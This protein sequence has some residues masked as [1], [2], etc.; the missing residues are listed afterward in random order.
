MH[1]QLDDLNEQQRLAVTQTPSAMLVFAGAGSGKTRVITYRIAWLIE[2]G[3]R[4]DSILAVTFTNKAAREMRERIEN[5]IGEKARNLWMGTFHSVCGRLLRI[6][7]DKIGIDKNF[8]IYDDADQLS[9][10]RE[11]LKK[12]GKDEKSFTP[13]SVLSEIS[14]AK[15]KLIS[16]E[17]Y[18]R[19]SMSYF[20]NEVAKLYPKYQE[21]LR[22]N[23]ALD[24]DDMIMFTV[25]LLQERKDV[26]DTIQRR[27]SHVLVDEFQ[28]VNLAQYELVRLLAEKHGN[29]T[30]VGD[31][32]QSI[33]AW[34]GADV[35]L[36][37]KFS[38][39]FKDAKIIMLE[40]NYRSTSCILQCANEVIK[41]NRTRA[42]K[43]LWTKNATGEPVSITEVGT[44]NDEAMLVADT[45]I[46]DTRTKDRKFGDFAVLY[47][48]N[49]QSRVLEETFLLMS[50]PYV[51]VGGLR[52]YERKE[53]KD[54]VAY[55][56][57]VANPYDEVSLRR[58]I[59]IPTR[60]IGDATIQKFENA[61][62]GEGLWF[63]LLKY[64]SLGL[65]SKVEHAV[66]QFV[67]CIQSAQE[68]IPQMSSQKIVTHILQ[69]S[70]Y[71]DM[72][73]SEKTEESQ[74]R[75]ENLQEFITVAIQHD[76]TSDEP[77]L[78]TFLQE[79]SLF[80]DVDSYQESPDVVTL[81][82]AHA[83]KGLEFPVVFVVGMEEGIFPH[84]RSLNTNAEIEEER[85]LCYVAMTRAK[86]ELHMIHA[87]RRNSFGQPIFNEPSR[88]L[89]NIP[90]HL[91]KSLRAESKRAIITD[92]R[93]P[94]YQVYSN[95]QTSKNLKAPDWTPPFQVGQQVRHPEF[96]NGI[97][98][99][100]SP[101]KDDCEVTVTFPGVT[102][103][104]RLMQKFAKLEKV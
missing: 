63:G 66:A 57:V 38:T 60:G 52:F 54:I 17:D 80:T 61:S 98:I 53:I 28:D 29:I 24:F 99:A 12:F 20:E 89:E 64:Y 32:D 73:R 51:L 41:H 88:F 100:C 76:V 33:Y 11:I 56:R 1:I 13:R 75:L 43:K 68:L 79:I 50:I 55:L 93:A 2:Q 6:Y 49:A 23:N 48:T 104:K 67:S 92:R 45:I 31:D 81:M 59:N 96:G 91:T 39:E 36:I 90:P 3:A 97:V 83:A 85:R 34:R 87:T 94:S 95:E 86:E 74:E 26:R 9:L 22:K 62:N 69:H 14:R 46:G 84:A 37:H 5:L 71:L 103:T 25:R 47:R 10:M 72:L 21:L 77:G 15:E 30:V 16:H 27:F 78:T 19:S 70:G 8:V 101:V 42:Q 18:A 7:G 44:E 102:G 65:S 58:I 35:S 40:Q 82:T 4:P